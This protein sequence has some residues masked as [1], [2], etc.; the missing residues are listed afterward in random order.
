MILTTKINSS[1]L[2]K[3]PIAELLKYAPDSNGQAPAI[4]SVPPTRHGPKPAIGSLQVVLDGPAVAVLKKHGI[5]T[6]ISTGGVNYIFRQVIEGC[7][8]EQIRSLF[9][10]NILFLREPRLRTLAA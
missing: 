8:D 1:N 2:E 10:S 3:S 9:A 6:D 4:G 5:D 7:T